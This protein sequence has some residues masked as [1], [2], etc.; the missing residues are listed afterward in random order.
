MFGG[1][2]FKLANCDPWVDYKVRDLW[3]AGL[4]QARKLT[5][6]VAEV[7]YVQTQQN[8]TYHKNNLRALEEWERNRQAE[9]DIAEEREKLRMILDPPKI[10]PRYIAWAESFR[11]PKCR[12]EVWVLEGPSCVGKTEW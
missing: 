8:V 10:Y 1:E 9:E 11:V 5:F 3:I 2:V 4:L 7:M 12:R 6:A